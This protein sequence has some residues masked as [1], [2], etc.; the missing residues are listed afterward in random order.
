M[1]R[2]YESDG[3]VSVD[4]ETSNLPSKK[5]KVTFDF[6]KSDDDLE[7]D[8]LFDKDSEMTQLLNWEIY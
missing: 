4:E 8:S 1:R 2:E 3:E 7:N 6:Y 5:A